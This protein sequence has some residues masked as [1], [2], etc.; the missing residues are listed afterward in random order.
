ME[1][2]ELKLETLKTFLESSGIEVVRVYTPTFEA[3]GEI[4]MVKSLRSD[5]EDCLRETWE[6]LKQENVTKV[7]I[8]GVYE[9]LY[10]G[11]EEGETISRYAVRMT[12]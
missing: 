9:M 10:A 7:Y 1:N 5:T 4:K 11:K 8:L 3:D 12:W 2:D 6:F